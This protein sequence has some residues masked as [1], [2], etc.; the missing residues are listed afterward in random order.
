M[1][2][3]KLQAKTMT[4]GQPQHQGLLQA[5]YNDQMRANMQ[6]G[7]ARNGFESAT[8]QDGGLYR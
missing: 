5:T 2:N 3:V 8:G 4:V 7:G 1:A 6:E